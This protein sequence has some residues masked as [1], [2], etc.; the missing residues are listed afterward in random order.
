LVREILHPNRVLSE[1]G[2]EAAEKRRRLLSST[3]VLCRAVRPDTFVAAA[4]VQSPT[5]D[6]LKQYED[7]L[8]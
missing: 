8:P 2:E 5:R 1:T 4:P 3:A 7:E 6:P